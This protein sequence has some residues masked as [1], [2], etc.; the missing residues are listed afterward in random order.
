MYREERGRDPGRG[1][2]VCCFHPG[3]PRRPRSDAGRWPASSWS[4]GAGWGAA[5]CPREGVPAA[6]RAQGPART[7]LPASDPPQPAARLT[8]P[9]SPKLSRGGPTPRPTLLPSVGPEPGH[10]GPQRWPE[11]LRREASARPPQP[12]G[13]SSRPSVDPRPGSRRARWDRT[14]DTPPRGAVWP[15]GQRRPAL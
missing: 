10:P 4:G 2:E 15:W 13:P 6:H 5:A 7:R 9:L 11:R 8:L 14:G 1:S 12:G 3:H